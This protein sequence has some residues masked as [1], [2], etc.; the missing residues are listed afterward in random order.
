M[1][2]MV[3]KK[4]G[5]VDIIAFL[6][7]SSLFTVPVLVLMSLYFEGWQL[8]K[9]SIHTASMTSVY[10]VLWQTIGN[11]LIGYGIWNFLISRYNA[12]TVTPWALLVPV[13]GMMAS[14]LMLDEPMPQWKIMAA[15]L[16]LTGLGLNIYI[17]VRK[18]KKARMNQ[19]T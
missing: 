17:S 1:G 18:G 16:I 11:T 12:A 7:Y 10:V 6:A 15:L 5:K 13:F 14:Y 8:I 9:T 2:N 19:I 3:I 4:A